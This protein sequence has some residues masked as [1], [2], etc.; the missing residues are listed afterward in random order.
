[1]GR[2]YRN[3]I[4]TFLLAGST[5]TALLLTV[6]EPIAN[7]MIPR[8][9]RPVAHPP[10]VAPP[11]ITPPK[12]YRAPKV[13]KKAVTKKKSKAKKK[14]TVRKTS[15][16]LREKAKTQKAK[17]KTTTKKTVKKAKASKEKDKS[18]S[19]KRR[20]AE[21][22]QTIPAGKRE[23]FKSMQGQLNALGFDLG[24]A[25]GVYGPKTEQAF[26]DFL[27]KFG[28]S[29]PNK[30]QEAYR[31]L[32]AGNMVDAQPFVTLYITQNQDL[33]RPKLADGAQAPGMMISTGGGSSGGASVATLSNDKSGSGG[34]EIKPVAMDGP[35]NEGASKPSAHAPATKD[36]IGKLHTDMQ[37][38]GMDPGMLTGVSG[39]AAIDRIYDWMDRSGGN[40]HESIFT[41]V[42]DHMQTLQGLPGGMQTATAK[43]LQGTGGGVKPTGGTVK[44][45]QGSVSPAA[46]PLNPGGSSFTGGRIEKP[47]ILAVGPGSVPVG[48]FGS[49]GVS[50]PGKTG[51]SGGSSGGSGGGSGSSGGSGAG[52][53]RGGSGGSDGGSSGYSRKDDP[54]YDPPR[55]DPSEFDALKAKADEFKKALE[56]EKFD[57]DM[58]IPNVAELDSSKIDWAIY[59]KMKIY[60]ALK[61]RA[62]YYSSGGHQEIIENRLMLID[63]HIAK[64]EIALSAMETAKGEAFISAH[65][66]H[67][68]QIADLDDYLERSIKRIFFFKEITIEQIQRYASSSDAHGVGQYQ[69]YTERLKNMHREAD[70]TRGYYSRRMQELKS[71]EGFE[72][73]LNMELRRAGYIGNAANL[74]EAEKNII[75]YQS[76]LENTIAD[77]KS[78]AAKLSNDLKDVASQINNLAAAKANAGGDIAGQEVAQT[79]LEDL[80]RE[81]DSSTSE[82]DLIMAQEGEG[83][84]ETKPDKKPRPDKKEPRPDPDGQSPDPADP[85]YKS[86]EPDPDA[87]GGGNPP[88]PDGSGGGNPP[89]PDA[90]PPDPSDGAAPPDAD[91]PDGSPPAPDKDVAGGGTPPDGAAPGPDPDDVLTAGVTDPDMDYQGRIDAT[92]EMLDG[93]IASIKQYEAEINSI[94]RRTD[95]SPEEKARIIDGLKSSIDAQKIF[96]DNARKNLA[97]MGSEWDGYQGRSFDGYDPYEVNLT[98]V[99][100][101]ELTDIHNTIEEFQTEYDRAH[102]IIDATTEGN[103]NYELHQRVRDL[104]EQA[105]ANQTSLDDLV[106]QIHKYGDA[107]HT[108]R[109]QGEL[110][111]LAALADEEIYRQHDYMKR[112]EK[113]LFWSAI[114]V[115]AAGGGA[116]ATAVSEGGAIALTA[117]KAKGVQVVFNAT[118]GAIEGY[119][120]EGIGGAFIR[121]TEE[122]ARE[123]LPV[124]TL[125]DLSDKRPDGK[126]SISLSALRDVGNLIGLKEMSPVLL[127]KARQAKA[128]LFKV[129]PTEQQKLI[130]RAAEQAKQQGIDQVKAW[131]KAQF[132]FQK[133]E[134]SGNVTQTIRDNLA[135]ATMAVDSSDEAKLVMKGASSNVQYQFNQ[136]QKTLIKE[137][138]NEI[139]IEE[140]QKLGWSGAALE[141]KS[142]R[143]ASSAGTVGMDDDIALAEPSLFDRYGDNGSLKYSGPKDPDYLADMKAFNNEFKGSNADA[144]RA[145]W[146]KDAKKAMNEA[147]KRVTGH[148]AE[149]S[150]I[151]MTTGEHVEAF[152]D[153]RLLISGT[154]NS[155]SAGW[156]EQSASVAGYKVIEGKGIVAAEK[157]GLGNGPGSL[158]NMNMDEVM[159]ATTQIKTSARE[160]LKD[161]VGKAM[162]VKPGM[163][164]PEK[165][166]KQLQILRDI[167]DGYHNPASANR[168]LIEQTGTNLAKTLESLPGHFES[169]LKFK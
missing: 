77:I 111:R 15:K 154:S 88:D 28:Q 31:M 119:V 74:A 44:P 94:N 159:Q 63:N 164:I 91:G 37:A 40:M 73:I 61:E 121:A 156:A 68:K 53:D 133:A 17:T 47:G 20:K 106:E 162:K 11:R 144:S 97:D 107:I 10:R 78:D 112:A 163:K 52:S 14:A 32:Q 58:D 80:R 92:Q 25:D 131:Q 109:K 128:A 45:T 95:I 90:T 81:I 129:V 103:D 132:D 147:Y 69:V 18:K 85:D 35:G 126:L 50:G 140:M 33:V 135:K 62:K 141:T 87:S 161:Y 99:R 145:L 5:L 157:L 12:V 142:V 152:K 75:F 48:S 4:R 38:L 168:A 123:L 76:V 98:D 41:L 113:A 82:Y 71:P 6:P 16:K 150:N 13:P 83:D 46:D 30:A 2:P 124:N 110:E 89:D 114:G 79:D 130:G 125:I 127:D 134:A 49:G 117:A 96:A 158:G 67:Q 39:E 34:N 43:P 29:H 100:I 42:E 65:K 108:T 36:Q 148:S 146:E 120:T 167:Q 105:K 60:K 102:K 165:T 118:T 166:Q 115:G 7:P 138:V 23:I 57:P 66:I 86:P 149:A 59:E 101:Q 55:F 8:H 72:R 122:S 70:E 136:T 9:E 143:N 116:I 151:S 51:G 169:M 64:Y 26:I 56:T 160:L 3:I 27:V 104:V 22:K 24:T 84:T 1:M 153:G 155:S 54:K 19:S 137:P 21:Y 93:H 139:W